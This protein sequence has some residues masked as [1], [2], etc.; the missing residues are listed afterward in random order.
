MK[1][2]VVEDD[3]KL[4]SFLQRMLTEE[5]YIVDRCALGGEA[6]AMA[7]SG[8]YHLILLDWM[9]PD[10]N[11][12]AVCRQL[13][14]A[15]VSS[16]VIMLTARG[17]LG[18]RVLGLE[19]GADDYMVKPFEVEE[20]VARVA[21]VLR[22]TE[23]QLNVRVG[24]LEL[25]RATR[26]ARLAG[27]PIDLTTREFAIL[28]YL[29]GRVGEAVTRSELLSRVWSIHFDPESNVVD[30]HIARLREKLGDHASLIETVRGRGYRVAAQ[31]EAQR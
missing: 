22:R 17:E 12:L 11:G 21:A 25:N 10:T 4:A 9:L 31:P 16:A 14:E 24:P 18:E 19:A 2:L 29:V 7:K 5:G 27:R 28:L 8:L 26:I 3:R 1:L 13:R 23:G 30:V 15:G 6:L 20:L